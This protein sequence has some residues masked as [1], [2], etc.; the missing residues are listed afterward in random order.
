[1][2]MQLTSYYVFQQSFKLLSKKQ[3]GNVKI[4]PIFA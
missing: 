2:A 4:T 1:M 3:D